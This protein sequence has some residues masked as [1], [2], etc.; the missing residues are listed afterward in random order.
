MLFNL[1]L[2]GSLLLAPVV[3]AVSS[4]FD[5]TIVRRQSAPTV[6]T[7]LNSAGAIYVKDNGT[8]STVTGTF[9]VPTLSG[10]LGDSA[11]IWVGIDDGTCTSAAFQTGLVTIVDGFGTQV[12]GKA[13]LN[14]VFTFVSLFLS[15][16]A[17]AQFHP[18][19]PLNLTVINISP[20][21]LVTLTI[22]TTS[23][24]TGTAI[25]YDHS[26][27]ESVSVTLNSTAPLCRRDVEWNTQGV[28]I[29]Y[30]VIPL[31][32]FGK[33]EFMNAMATGPTGEQYFPSNATIMEYV[34]NN[35]IVTNVS[36]NDTSVT[37][38]YI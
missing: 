28:T 38:E 15:W 25:I 1:A 6:N 17:W 35:T 29:A 37:I 3:L 9:T 2:F 23:T 8:F 18:K 14:H 13:A 19:G 11:A 12:G 21:D 32:N 16:T 24:T 34:Q 22:V 7:T 36:T 10:A 20:G 30:N 4:G 31:A 5:A 26:N 33:V 27:G